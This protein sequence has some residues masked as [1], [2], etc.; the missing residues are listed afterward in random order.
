MAAVSSFSMYQSTSGM[1][2]SQ[3]NG[4]N[5]QP[6]TSQAP[7]PVGSLFKRKPIKITFNTRR[8]SSLL[9]KEDDAL[10][11]TSFVP[12]QLHAKKSDNTTQKNKAASPPRQPLWDRPLAFV[13]AGG[14]IQGPQPPSTVPAAQPSVSTNDAPPASTPQASRPMFVSIPP[15]QTVFY[16]GEG[17]CECGNTCLKCLLLQDVAKFSYIVNK[18][19]QLPSS[20]RATGSV[21]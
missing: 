15:A 10:A 6:S 19:P 2:I 8:T 16:D 20:T 5:G 11:S 1:G 13:S 9:E 12:P 4:N 3:I 18:G 21:H 7:T 17:A 14:A